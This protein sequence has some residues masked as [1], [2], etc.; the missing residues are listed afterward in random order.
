MEEIPDCLQRKRKSNSMQI[1]L[2]ILMV[3]ILLVLINRRNLCLEY[4]DDAVE[5]PLPSQCQGKR[6]TRSILWLCKTQYSP[7]GRI[8][9]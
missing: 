5:N 6:C 9:E 7:E 2:F 3:E 8:F 4:H 1:I